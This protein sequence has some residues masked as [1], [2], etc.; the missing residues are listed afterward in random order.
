MKNLYHLA[1]QWP[2]FETIHTQIYKY[3]YSFD[4]RLITYFRESPDDTFNWLIGKNTYCIE[5]KTMYGN[6]IWLY[7]YYNVSYSIQ[8]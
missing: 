6:C 3:L 5:N 7:N 1:M 2:M 4:D 8:R